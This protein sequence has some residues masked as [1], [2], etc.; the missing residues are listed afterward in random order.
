[1]HLP[2]LR[3]HEQHRKE[4]RGVKRRER[5]RESKN[6]RVRLTGVVGV[7]L[8]VVVAIAVEEEEDESLM[9]FF[10]CFSNF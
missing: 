5:G 4:R 7:V 8:V 3:K 6:V 1:M 2:Q 9:L 10:C